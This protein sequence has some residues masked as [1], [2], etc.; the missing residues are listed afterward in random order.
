M[1]LP[2]LRNVGQLIKGG[3]RKVKEF[4]FDPFKEEPTLVFKVGEG[5][6]PGQKK[7]AKEKIDELIAVGS[8]FP[9]SLDS[10]MS[11][12]DASNVQTNLWIK[13]RQGEVL[14]P[15]QRAAGKEASSAFQSQLSNAALGFMS[16]G[17]GFV[18]KSVAEELAKR[19]LTPAQKMINAIKGIKPLRGTQE[20][21]LTKGRA[22]Q[23]AKS[24]RAGKTVAGEA[25]FIA[26][27]AAL[28][29]KLPMVQFE[30][31]RGKLTQ[32]DIDDLFNIVKHNPVITNWEK[33]SAR[34]GL[35]KMLGKTGTS[36]PTKGEISLLD[37]VFGKEFTDA[38]MSKRPFWDKFKEAIGQVA[39]VPRS[40]MSSF[41]LSF[42]GRQ[43]SFA[44]PT[45]RKEFFNSWKNQF[46]WFGSEKAYLNSVDDLINTKHYKLAKESGVSFTDIG[47][48]MSKREEGFASQWAE[49]IPILGRGVRAS[50][51]AYTGFANKFR[52]DIFG[53]M[54]DDATKQGVAIT[55][56]LT[57]SIAKFVNNATGRGSLGGLE[58]SATVLN[59]AFFSPRLMA[60]RLSLLNPKYYITQP[61]FVRKQALKSLLG[62][63]STVATVLTLAKL[64]GAEVETDPRSSD[65]AKIKINNTRID[66][67]GGF[68]QYI[69]SAAQLISG[70]YISSI[71]GKKITL[72][73]GFKPLTR[74]DI[75]LRQIE[76]KEA[77]VLSFITDLLRGQDFTGEKI[78][79]GKEV[80]D[81]FTPMVISDIYELAQ[82]D[83]GLLP[84][85]VLGIFGIGIQTYKGKVSKS[86]DSLLKTTGG[87]KIPS[88]KGVGSF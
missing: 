19:T 6:S 23:I 37:D 15:T 48:I 5:L 49:K 31:L 46:K 88:L 85:G 66:I 61:A 20:T 51:R 30:S 16:P 1:P 74:Y 70:T 87:A 58:R 33:I 64:G 24:L 2:T 34:E 60:S 17:S 38:I 54:I 62:F 47:R 57:K 26:E 83:P 65:F 44:G 69:R 12:R 68:Q 72:G 10:P 14:T 13:M 22:I 42:G 71:T 52:M 21:L 8:S 11:L 4:L 39:N 81:L 32:A 9:A 73:E 35:S 40:V 76:N 84:I 78:N 36:L 28:K 63:A 41:D 29:G 53:K 55:P 80:V 50:G 45:F 18:K 79:I 27:K 86:R 25:G 82:E 77:P 3:F 59:A 56:D 43:G 67:L 75:L 7:T